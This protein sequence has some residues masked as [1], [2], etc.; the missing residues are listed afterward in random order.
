MEQKS[1]WSA[2]LTNGLI[3]GLAGIVYSLIIYF[4]NL[5]FNKSFGYL[6]L[7]ITAVL[8][9]YLVRSYRNNYLSGYI[10]YGQAVGAGVVIFLYYSVISA[11]FMYILYTVIDTGLTDKML[12]YV[13]ETMVKKGIPEA[14]LDKVMAVQKKILRPGIMAPL[15][16]VNNML[17]GTIISLIVAIFVRREGNP[18]VDQD[19]N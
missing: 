8:L 14:S 17:A 15:S 7:L 5:T 1:V 13:E 3:L 9:Y 10:S 19:N 18:L 12:A 4:F 16:I 2:N 6:F 11:I